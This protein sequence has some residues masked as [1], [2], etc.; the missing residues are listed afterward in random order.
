M[1][2]FTGKSSDSQI[3][4]I[5]PQEKIEEQTQEL[6][7]QSN[8][9]QGEDRKKKD[10]LDKGARYI[11]DINKISAEDRFIINDVTLAIPPSTIRIDRNNIHY[12]WHTLRSKHPTK[13]KSGHG[14]IQVGLTIYFVG[15]PAINEGLRRL[16]VQLELLV[17]QQRYLL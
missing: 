10:V 6:L 9:T 5:D 7:S 3:L 8:K 12:R 1:V 17:M 2:T 11:S 16:V 15:I 13:V 4:P 14:N